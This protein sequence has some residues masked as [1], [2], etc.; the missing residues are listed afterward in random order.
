MVSQTCVTTGECPDILVNNSKMTPFGP[1]N[2]AATM[3]TVTA[4]S[5]LAHFV[6]HALLTTVIIEDGGLGMQTDQGLGCGPVAGEVRTS[7]V[8]RV[9]WERCA[10][11][12]SSEIDRGVHKSERRLPSTHTKLR[13]SKVDAGGERLQQPRGYA[14]AVF[15]AL[16]DPIVVMDLDGRVKHANRQFLREV[17]QTQE[18][19]LGKTPSDLG[20]LSSEQF[21]QLK[22]EVVPKLIS[23]GSLVN[24]ETI[25]QRPDGRSF[26]ALLSFGLLRSATGEPQ[27]VVGASRDISLIKEAHK[28]TAEKEETLQALFHA[29]PESLFLLDP[30]GRVL[31]CNE[32]AA[33]RVGWSMQEIV[34]GALVDCVAKIAP[35][36]L[37]ERRMAKIAEVF[38]SGEP[39]YFTDER[40]GLVLEH[41]LYPIL[42]DRNQVTSIVI[43]ARDIT[44][45][46]EAQ[47]E[48]HEYC[49]RLRSA[50]QLASL[51]TLSATLVHE[52]TQPL[53]VIRLANQTALAEL[54]K[55]NCPDVI[56]RDLEA[57]LT[58]SATIAAT[59]NRFRDYARQS[60]RTKETEVHIG[61]VAEWTIRLLEHSAQQARVTVRTENLDALPPIRMRE[62][63]LE[64]L[65]FAL[66]QNAIQAADGEKDCCL[67][68]AGAVRGDAIELRFQDDCG[69]IEPACLQR[70]FEPFFTTKP[71]GKGTGLGLCIAHR[72]VQ[73]R[74]GQISVQSQRGKGTTFTVILPRK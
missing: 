27:A 28:A 29:I 15:D 53:S 35:S 48:L 39:A 47:K 36:D 40:N 67:L 33:K 59:I 13:R 38:R 45:Q 65:F 43:F 4:C 7:A 70:I 32:T 54:K 61:G 44:K 49:E 3:D 14:E 1:P 58:A 26:P 5:F 37:C 34:G 31:A 62:N 69:G 46:M 52:L 68:I 55:L 41:T 22:S 71:P 57:S 42:N 18:Q 60:T 10:V 56:N 2:D 63:D 11:D 12:H 17:G 9:R 73:Q 72:I 20:L 21:L 6:L 64:Q 23:E 74:G 30:Q 66:A 25:A 24:I 19:V 50:E 51:G 16:P 8:D